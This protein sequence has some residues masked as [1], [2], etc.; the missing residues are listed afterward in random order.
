MMDLEKVNIGILAR[1]FTNYSVSTTGQSYTKV[2]TK[3]G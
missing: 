2:G 1:I 3:L